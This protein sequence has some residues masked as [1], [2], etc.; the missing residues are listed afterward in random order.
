MGEGK[1]RHSDGSVEKVILAKPQSFMN[2]SGGPTSKLC[3]EYDCPVEELIVIHDE[4]D[5]DPGTVKVKKGGG[6]AGHNGLK[7]IIEKCG[8][9]EFLRVRHW[10]RPPSRKDERGRFRAW[11]PE[12]GCKGRFRPGMPA[13]CRS[14]GIAAGKRPG[15]NTGCVQSA[16]SHRIKSRLR[17]QSGSFFAQKKSRRVAHTTNNV[18][19]R[20]LWCTCVAQQCANVGSAGK[21]AVQEHCWKE[22]GSA[23]VHRCSAPFLVLLAAS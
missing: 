23:A 2:L 22:C 14:S 17:K 18:F 1:L 21:A 12:K 7:S 16:L 20:L 6:H 8:S 19:R 9:R 10:H 11:H 5:I 13:C 15:K 3:K 4:L